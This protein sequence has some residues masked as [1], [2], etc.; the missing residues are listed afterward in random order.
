LGK[1]GDCAIFAGEKL[2]KF[3]RFLFRRE[4]NKTEHLHR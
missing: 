3:R 1:L 4:M 2:R